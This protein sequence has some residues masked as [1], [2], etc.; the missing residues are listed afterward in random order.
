[1][2]EPL[3][4]AAAAIGADGFFFETHPHPDQSPSDGANMIPLSE[5]EAVAERI[6]TIWETVRTFSA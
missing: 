5:F 4:R 2:V 1:M 3:A 6:M